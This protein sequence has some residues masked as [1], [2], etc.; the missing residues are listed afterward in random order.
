MKYDVT[1]GMPVF[2]GVDYINRSL[3]SALNQTYD[4]IE[5]LI[6]DD[7]SLDGSVDI[8]KQL[9]RSHPKG[10]YTFDYSYL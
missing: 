4:S 6:I 1:I 3:E 2:Q 5:F 7:G 10:A 9:I 8:V